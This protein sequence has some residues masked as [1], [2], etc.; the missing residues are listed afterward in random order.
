M[1]Y[2]TEEIIR[3]LKAARKDRRMSQRVL[4]EKTGIAQSHISKIENGSVDITVS[5][6][7]ELARALE[8]EVM[9]VPRRLIPAVQSMTRSARR[10]GSDDTADAAMVREPKPA[11][12]LD[13]D[14]D[15]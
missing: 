11:Y 14:D 2:N 15:A 1:S 5:T 10:G 8:L 13:E 12:S 7:V 6:L 4:S 3:L 9:L